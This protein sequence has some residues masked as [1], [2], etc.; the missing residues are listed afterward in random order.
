MNRRTL[1][2]LGAFLVIMA[3]L[4]LITLTLA[5]CGDP[6]GVYSENHAAGFGWNC[7]LGAEN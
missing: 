4:V 5:G 1:A 6:G 2:D 3:S 7:D